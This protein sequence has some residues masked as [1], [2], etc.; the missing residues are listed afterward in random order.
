MVPMTQCS[1]HLGGDVPLPLTLSGGV[2]YTSV[3]PAGE[4]EARR[5]ARA[6]I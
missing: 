4:E 5:Q 6:Q 1:L 2:T 3:T